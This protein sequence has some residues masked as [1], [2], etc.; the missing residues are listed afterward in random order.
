MG[1]YEADIRAVLAHRHDNGAD[2]WATPDGRI[3][4]GN[5]FSTISSLGILYELGVGPG[6]EAVEGGLSLILNACCEDGRIRVAPKAP[7]YP[8]YIAEAARM[9]CRFGL[10]G[11]EALQRTVSYLIEN[12]VHRKAGANPDLLLPW[13]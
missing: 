9:L 10:T 4:V 12:V 5:P 1:A 8:C 7:S 2:F 6:H 13:G 3:Y 11:H